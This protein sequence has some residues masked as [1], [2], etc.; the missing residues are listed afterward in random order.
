[1]EEIA[2]AED[3]DVGN[4]EHDEPREMVPGA[5]PVS[6]RRWG[7]PL[8]VQM[9]RSSGHMQ[10]LHP[11]RLGENTLKSLEKRQPPTISASLFNN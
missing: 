9:Q 3:E 5:L 2:L 11:P 4:R 6:S 7:P 1:V 8:E 10:K